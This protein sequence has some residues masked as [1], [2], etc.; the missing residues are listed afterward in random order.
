MPV[1]DGTITVP[2]FLHTSHTGEYPFL[3]HQNRQSVACA[4]ASI[5]IDLTALS[6]SCPPE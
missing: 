2:L 4:S 3:L 6:R 5:P 1:A